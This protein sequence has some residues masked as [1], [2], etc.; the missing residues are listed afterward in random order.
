VAHISISGVHVR[1]RHAPG[2]VTSE[3]SHL[4]IH[5]DALKQS[6]TTLVKQGVPPP[7]FE[8]GYREWDSVKG[9]V[10]TVSVAEAVGLVDQTLGQ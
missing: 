9:G 4:P 1:N 10:F 8:R 5:Q 3:L 6:L 2:G 7:D